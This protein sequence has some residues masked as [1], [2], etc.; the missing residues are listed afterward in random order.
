[1]LY[2]CAQTQYKQERWA[3]EN[4]RRQ[5]LEPFLPT[6]RHRIKDGSYS[7]RLLFPSYIIVGLEH[8]TQWP[9]VQRTLGIKQVLVFQP[10]RRE[11]MEPSEIPTEAVESLR[12]IAVP[13]ERN[14]PTRITKGCYVRIL[15][16]V[17]AGQEG[18]DRALVEWA[19]NVKATLLVS[20]FNRQIRAQFFLKDLAHAESIDRPG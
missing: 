5:G 11:Y 6:Y 14:E 1:M 2:I 15:S 8:Q 20:I 19:D 17:F 12:S 16:G 10:R 13:D 3:G 7:V 9:I 4:L 18:A